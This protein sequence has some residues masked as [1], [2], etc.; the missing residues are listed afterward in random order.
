MYCVFYVVCSVLR[1]LAFN[2]R[3]HSV[4]THE[5]KAFC[6]HNSPAQSYEHKAEHGPEQRAE[7]GRAEQFN[8]KSAILKCVN[9]G[10]YFALDF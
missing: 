3:I 8:N 9:I 7:R 6:V 5:F 10:C 1:A 2:N 4:A